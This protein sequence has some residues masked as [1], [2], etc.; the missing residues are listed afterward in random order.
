MTQTAV[1]GYPALL[2]KDTVDPNIYTL[3]WTDGLY[4]YTLYG[5]FDS[6]SQ[7]MRFAESV[8]LK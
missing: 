4:N 8:K 5:I 3:T 7:L 1:F 2:M 6:V